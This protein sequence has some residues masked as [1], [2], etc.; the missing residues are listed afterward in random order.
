MHDAAEMGTD[1][2]RRVHRLSMRTVV[3]CDTD[4]GNW[5]QESSGL[6]D[7]YGWREP[8]TRRL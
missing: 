2:V 7:D 6:D 8:D 1:F 4:M 5:L 3:Y